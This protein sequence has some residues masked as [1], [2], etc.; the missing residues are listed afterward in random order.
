MGQQRTHWPDGALCF[1]QS[2]AAMQFIDAV[3]GSYLCETVD[4]ILAQFR[5][6]QVEKGAIPRSPATNR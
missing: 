4:L 6:K 1:P 3:E 2:G 5:T